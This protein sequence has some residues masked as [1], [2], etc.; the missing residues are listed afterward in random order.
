MHPCTLGYGIK[1]YVPF[2]LALA[3]EDAGKT[4][5]VRMA[6][7]FYILYV[8][9]TPYYYYIIRSRIKNS[10]GAVWTRSIVLWPIVTQLRRLR[11]WLHHKFGLLSV[12]K[13]NQLLL[14][15]TRPKMGTLYSVV[16]ILGLLY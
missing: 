13:N 11:I 1:G 9:S 2:K 8:W 15:C 14:F 10:L 3:V 12:Y 5:N 6:E 4:G 7:I 16:I